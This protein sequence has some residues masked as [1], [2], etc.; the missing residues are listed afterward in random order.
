MQNQQ[1]MLESFKKDLAEIHSDWKLLLAQKDQA[2]DPNFLKKVATDIQNL[3][4]DAT[5]MGSTETFK[6]QADLV[7][8]LLSTPWGAPFVDETT[9]IE[10]AHAFSRKPPSI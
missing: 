2:S 9:L 1:Q 8:F 3:D 4:R 5:Q 7:H 6:E 10:A